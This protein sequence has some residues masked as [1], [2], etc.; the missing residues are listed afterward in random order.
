MVSATTS[1]SAIN[2]GKLTPKK[3]IGFASALKISHPGIVIQIINMYRAE[4]KVV[5]NNFCHLVIGGRISGVC[6][7]H[8]EISFTH[9]KTNT[10]SLSIKSQ[11]LRGLLTHFLLGKFLLILCNYIQQPEHD[12]MQNNGSSGTT[13]LFG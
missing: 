1:F 7:T 5:A 11:I 4:C 10:L 8:L 2:E 13:L 3:V 12:P 9:N 6:V